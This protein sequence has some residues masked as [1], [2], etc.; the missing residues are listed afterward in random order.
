MATNTTKESWEFMNN[1]V[2][3]T[4]VLDKLDGM[5]LPFVRVI[6]LGERMGIDTEEQDFQSFLRIFDQSQI[7]E[8]HR[9]Y[10]SKNV[11]LS[12]LSSTVIGRVLTLV[13]SQPM[14]NTFKIF[15]NE[16]YRKPNTASGYRRYT[17]GVQELLMDQV[18]RYFIFIRSDWKMA[19]VYGSCLV[20]SVVF[21]VQYQEGLRKKIQEYYR[22]ANRRLFAN[23]PLSIV[24]DIMVQQSIALKV[25]VV[26]LFPGFVVSNELAQY[27]SNMNFP[28][29][30]EISV[31][32]RENNPLS[33][34]RDK[35]S[36]LLS[37][38]VVSQ[39]R[40]IMSAVGRYLSKINPKQVTVVTDMDLDIISYLPSLDPSL[41]WKISTPVD[42]MRIDRSGYGG[43]VLQNQ[44][45][46]LDGHVVFLI[47]DYKKIASLLSE[48]VVSF[49][50]LVDISKLN[51]IH[52]GDMTLAPYADNNMVQ[53]ICKSPFEIIPLS[54]EIYNEHF[55]AVVCREFGLFKSQ[56]GKMVGYDRM[57]D[58]TLVSRDVVDS[59]DS[60]TPM[61]TTVF[62]KLFVNQGRLDKLKNL[63]FI[64]RCLKKS[65]MHLNRTSKDMQYLYEWIVER[66]WR[67][68]P[69]NASVPGFTEFFEN[70]VTLDKYYRRLTQTSMP[71]ELVTLGETIPLGV[72]NAKGKAWLKLVYDMVPQLKE[73]AFSR[74]LSFYAVER[75]LNS[76]TAFDIS[77]IRDII[78]VINDEPHSMALPMA[79][80]RAVQQRNPG[81]QMRFRIYSASAQ[82]H[83]INSSA[84]ELFY[85]EVVSGNLDLQTIRTW[86]GVN[87]ALGKL[88]DRYLVYI[89]SR[90]DRRNLLDT[91]KT[92][93]GALSMVISESKFE[94]AA[95]EQVMEERFVN[96]EP[97]LYI[98]HAGKEMELPERELSEVDANLD[99]VPVEKPIE[100]KAE[101]YRG[102]AVTTGENI[103]GYLNRVKEVIISASK[104][105]S[106]TVLDIGCGKGQDIFKFNKYS[107]LRY[108]GIDQSQEEITEALRR[109]KD[110]VKTGAN[111][112]NYMVTKDA[113][114]V[115]PDWLSSAREFAKSGFFD[116]ISFQ[117]SIHYAFRSIT[118]LQA[119]VK[120]MAALSRDGTKVIITTLDDKQIV[121][122]VR[123]AKETAAGSYIY[124][125]R[126]NDYIISLDGYS[127]ELLMDGGYQNIGKTNDTSYDFT[128]FPKDAGARKAT[129]YPVPRDMFVSLMAKDGFML[130]DE[131]NAIG[132]DAEVQ[133]IRKYSLTESDKDMISLYKSYIFVK[134]S[135]EKPVEKP[136][137][138]KP[139]EKP[140]VEKPVVEQLEDKFVLYSADNYQKKAPGGLAA[141]SVKNAND[142]KELK[143]V[144]NW[145]RLLS[146]DGILPEELQIKL[147]NGEMFVSVEHAVEYFHVM[148]FDS[149]MANRLRVDLFQT[150]LSGGKDKKVFADFLKEFK[151]VVSE[152]KK[153]KV[154]KAQIV[155]KEKQWEDRRGEI[156][157]MIYE[158]KFGN[159][160]LENV[161][162]NTKNAR[163]YENTST[164][165]RSLE[166]LRAKKIASKGM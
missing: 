59:L 34:R 28:L 6:R 53:L 26:E 153:N 124:E 27:I 12:E 138:E 5:N 35:F 137:V 100:R 71:L 144:E 20:S 103:R 45:D 37:T 23:S 158:R 82:H 117:L 80:A 72:P 51:E 16:F 18:L 65:L 89:D 132:Y 96:F 68:S 114:E 73:S 54:E 127:R 44:L 141:E 126:S 143:K 146:D 93:I 135:V 36:T 108:L 129:E 102:A 95:P 33:Y 166:E 109:A 159:H 86:D 60:K 140:V 3:I 160:I 67:Y 155:E 125:Y 84:V 85:N 83:Q 17:Q 62:D 4:K 50:T 139:V 81:Q 40:S 110:E 94:G 151:S 13:C 149:E 130:L 87:E 157:N 92:N 10:T 52:L 61:A 46:N 57:L 30:E 133:Q 9:S 88:S 128:A 121:D 7:A 147:E 134:K 47:Q 120:N 116:L 75:F 8:F 142:Y 55:R 76:Q 99:E 91:F 90:N 49:M 66:G 165:H 29:V 77:E 107:N 15:Q 41:Q 58:E 69:M 164:L 104:G 98:K 106:F 43:G 150:E 163:L 64:L 31:E 112:F 161:L 162:L 78:A 42:M 152:Q 11:L 32:Q 115:S 123:R 1:E 39:E 101:G 25:P 113:F 111:V 136:V 22:L 48:R 118:S 122:R 24:D 156:L 56:S 2:L 70:E 19:Q 131:K 38:S 154:I 14:W 148:A 21:K 97:V 63:Y 74:D 119:L 79:I 145:R 105:N